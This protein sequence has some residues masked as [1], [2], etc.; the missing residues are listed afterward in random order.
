[1]FK[2]RILKGTISEVFKNAFETIKEDPKYGNVVINF[3]DF[4]LRKNIF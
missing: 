1:M 3:K 4:L 2:I